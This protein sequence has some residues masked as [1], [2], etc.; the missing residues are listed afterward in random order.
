MSTSQSRLQSER[1]AILVFTAIALLVLM[2]FLTFVVD[3]GILWV[4]RAQAQNAADAGALA[5]A[6]ARAFDDPGATP[7]EK[8]TSSA[9]KTAEQNLVWKEALSADVALTCPADV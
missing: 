8:T 1:G 7:G 5:G 4:S 2:G 6:I 3:N 9:K